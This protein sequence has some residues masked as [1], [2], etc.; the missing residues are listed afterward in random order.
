MNKFTHEIW[1]SPEILVPSKCDVDTSNCILE[2]SYVSPK[3]FSIIGVMPGNILEVE[4]NG[5][6]FYIQQL[7]L[8]SC[9]NGDQVDSVTRFSIE[10]PTEGNLG[11]KT[12]YD[13]LREAETEFRHNDVENEYYSSYPG[14]HRI[15]RPQEKELFVPVSLRSIYDEFI[16]FPKQKDLYLSRGIK[17]KRSYFLAG[18]PG[19]G[20]STFIRMLMA[21]SEEYNEVIS[22]QPLPQTRDYESLFNNIIKNRSKPLFLILEEFSRQVD[23]S[24]IAFILNAL[25]GLDQDSYSGMFIIATDNHPEKLDAALINRPGRFDRVIW[26]DNPS[27]DEVD[28]F[29]SKMNE[30]SGIK[31]IDN[32][33]LYGLSY[34]EIKEV[35]NICALWSINEERDVNQSDVEKAV[36]DLKDFTKK[37]E[38]FGYNQIS[39]NVQ[40]GDNKKKRRR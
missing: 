31:D 25:D 24:N 3:G 12:F 27:N 38:I 33:S 4:Y 1:G 23:E 35:M 37:T 20:K 9:S 39:P 10:T 17:H 29:V 2:R 19:N 40:G 22:V 14:S 11:I 7:N 21:N 32:R 36:I 16:K 13:M 18:P 15:L 30:K 6:T 8:N 5:H 26:L 28:I 34:A